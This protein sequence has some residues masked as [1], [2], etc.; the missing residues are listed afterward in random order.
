MVWGLLLLSTTAPKPA[1][2]K[3]Q[4]I[5]RNANPQDVQLLLH[6]LEAHYY[7]SSSSS[8]PPPPPPPPRSELSQ[9]CAQVLQQEPDWA[10]VGQAQAAAGGG[11]GAVQQ[12]PPVMQQQQ[13][14]Q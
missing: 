8:H 5:K 12:A 9:L 6:E 4:N 11:A 10:W 14:Q 2:D 13:Q 1:N 3:R 7:S